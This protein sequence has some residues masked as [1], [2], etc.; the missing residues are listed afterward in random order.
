MQGHQIFLIIFSMVVDFSYLG[1]CFWTLCYYTR[2]SLQNPGLSMKESFCLDCCFPCNSLR[3][4]SLIKED[5]SRPIKDVIFGVYDILMMSYLAYMTSSMCQYVSAFTLTINKAVFR[6]YLCLV[7]GYCQIGR[8]SIRV[9]LCRITKRFGPGASG[10]FNWC[11]GQGLSF[12]F[13]VNELYMTE[14]PWPILKRFSFGRGQACDLANLSTLGHSTL[15][16]W[17]QGVVS[18]VKMQASVFLSS[19]W[20]RRWIFHNIHVY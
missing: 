9:W 11:C 4:K 6:S 10:Q 19:H 16:T 1:S 3:F 15:L 17:W 14:P 2:T 12:I 18:C 13:T 7:Q 20:H 5:I 8:Y